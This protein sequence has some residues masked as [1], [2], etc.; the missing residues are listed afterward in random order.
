VL[1]KNLKNLASAEDIN[2]SEKR[3]SKLISRYLKT[4]SILNKTFQNRAAKHTKIN[5]AELTALDELIFQYKGI[6]LKQA[7]NILNLRPH[8]F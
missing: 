5:R 7:K 2:A 1:L 8:L 3:I 6:S 4:G